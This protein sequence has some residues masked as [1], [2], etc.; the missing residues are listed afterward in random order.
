MDKYQKY[1]ME[2]SRSYISYTF[3]GKETTCFL[4]NKIIIKQD[5]DITIT[6]YE[7]HITNKSIE[8]VVAINCGKEKKLNESIDPVYSSPKSGEQK[9]FSLEIDFENRIE[10]IKISFVD[11]IAEDL[12]IPIVYEEASKEVYYAKKEQERKDDLLKK[13]SIKVST[14]ADLVNIYF[15]PCSEEY[16]RSEIALYK[17]G[18]MLAK[19]KVEEDV[20]F[21]SI[22]GLAYGKYEFIMKQFNNKNVCIL[23][24]EKTPFKISPPIMPHRPCNV[25]S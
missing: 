23:E 21:K 13:A 8:S 7:L 18:M 2:L 10:A 14:G 20:F 24:T 11:N 9:R 6:K 4:E 25:I 19:Y 1:L 22:N 12:I 5:E 16:L 15:Q 17:D 3:K